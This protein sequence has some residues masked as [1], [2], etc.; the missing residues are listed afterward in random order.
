MVFKFSVLVDRRMVAFTRHAASGTQEY[1]RI[2]CNMVG[3]A[4]FAIDAN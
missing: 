2:E 4:S 1:I 3:V